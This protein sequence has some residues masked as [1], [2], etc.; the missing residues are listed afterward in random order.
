[1]AYHF[2]DKSDI[3]KAC[4]NYIN[5]NYQRILVERIESAN[6][7]KQI[8]A[9]YAESPFIWAQDFPHELS[10]KLLFYYLC[11]GDDEYKELNDQIR[12]SGIQRILLVLTQKC[13]LKQDIKELEAFAS[14]LQN[15]ISGSIIDAVTTNKESLTHAKKKTRDYVIEIIAQVEFQ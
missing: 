7:G 1:M 9:N 6:S 12:K 15:L 3:F 2:G 14:R 13:A 8:L 11:T 4:I 5:S 10:V